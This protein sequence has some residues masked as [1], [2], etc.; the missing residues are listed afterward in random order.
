MRRQRSTHRASGKAAA[1]YIYVYR[2]NGEA[3]AGYQ[4]R[5]K[6]G[7]GPDRQS[8]SRYFGAKAYHSLANALRAAI[9]WR[10]ANAEWL[11]NT[12]FVL[13]SPRRAD[14]LVE[15]VAAA[16]AAARKRAVQV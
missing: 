10:D 2:P 5:F 8:T 14:P 1:P 6:R 4:V 16:R 3:A 15:R 7:L 12:D 9:K 13:T 11:T